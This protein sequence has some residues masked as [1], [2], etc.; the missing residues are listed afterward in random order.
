MELVGPGGF[1]CA[2]GGDA[3]CVDVDAGVEA[4][5][6]GLVAFGFE[7]ADVFVEDGA[8]A[9]E[10]QGFVVPVV[11]AVP[12]E[13]DAGFDLAVFDVGEFEA[14]RGECFDGGVV[15]FVDAFHLGAKI[16]GWGFSG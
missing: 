2:D 5:E 13:F 10:G 1:A 16:A 8:V 9:F 14:V 11:F 6:E 3:G 7:V 12:D 15:D 4:G